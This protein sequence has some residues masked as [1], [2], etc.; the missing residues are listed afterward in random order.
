MFVGSSHKRKTKRFLINEITGMSGEKIKEK[1]YSYE[2]VLHRYNYLLKKEMK[3]LAKLSQGGKK[4]MIND[5]LIDRHSM[6]QEISSI[7]KKNPDFY[8]IYD[9]DEIIDILDTLR[10]ARLLNS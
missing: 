3:K 5:D 4:S 6:I 8:K 2:E 10:R 1:D 7:T 9:P